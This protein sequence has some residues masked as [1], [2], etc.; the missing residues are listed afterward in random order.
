MSHDQPR[1]SPRR[2]AWWVVA[3]VG[4]I[5]ACVGVG[6]GYVLFASTGS[7]ETRTGRADL[8]VEDIDRVAAV[9]SDFEAAWNAHDADAIRDVLTDDFLFE[10]F[11]PEGTNRQLDGIIDEYVE[12]DGRI[13]YLGDPFVVEIVGTASDEYDVS[14]LWVETVWSPTE[15]SFYGITNYRVVEHGGVMKIHRANPSYLWFRY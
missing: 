13:E 2:P 3:L 12:D 14:A 11:T 9:I 7:E 4:V 10:G 1:V 6:L 8:T 5:T 15:E